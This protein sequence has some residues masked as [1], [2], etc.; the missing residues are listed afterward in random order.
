MS[1]PVRVALVAE[2][3]TD[4]EILHAAIQEMLAPRSFDLK[5]LQPEE[6]VAF[7]GGGSAG[8][9]GGGWKGVFKWCIQA[10]ERNDSDLASDPLFIGHDLLV[11]HVDAEVANEKAARDLPQ[12]K[13]RLPCAKS[14]PPARASCDALRGVVKQVLGGSSMP[15]S[16]VL[17]TP[18]ASMETWVV[19]A[20]F[21][22]DAE[23]KKKNWECHKKPEGRLAAQAKTERFSK[24]QIEYRKRA[25]AFAARWSF[26]TSALPEARRFEEEFGAAMAQPASP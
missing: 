25:A 21:P 12:L 19:A 3:V 17:C 11:I 22:N 10:A 23:M 16:V 8:W 1:D 9:L 24:N 26:V 6:S 2:G 15:P 4:Y 14:C 20:F 13:G 7:T 5:L 18:A